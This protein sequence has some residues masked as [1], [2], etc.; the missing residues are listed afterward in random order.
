MRARNARYSAEEGGTGLRSDAQQLPS[1][2]LLLPEL[3][4]EP[5]GGCPLCAGG[6]INPGDEDRRLAITP[7][8]DSSPYRLLS[9]S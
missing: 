3:T 9:A 1:S 4:L 7:V 6:R 5:V 8:Y 2:A